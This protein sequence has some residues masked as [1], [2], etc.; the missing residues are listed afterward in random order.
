LTRFGGRRRDSGNRGFDDGRWKG[1]GRDVLKDNVFSKIMSKVLVDK[2]ILGGHGEEVFLLVFLVL[3]LVGGDVGED[4]E[5][6]DGGRG[7]RSTG[8]NISRAVRDVEEGVV[9]RVVKDRPS[10]FGGWGIW[11]KGLEDMGGDVKGTWVVPGVVRALEDL[12]DGGGSVRNIL[13]VDIIK[14]RPGGDRD[15]GKG[16]GDNN[17][18]LGRVERHSILN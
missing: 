9:L 16:R 11:D 13:L 15:V 14:G 2:G 10:E 8:D 5:T 4:V 12:K 17:G 6:K 18:G 7:D 1:G 3:G